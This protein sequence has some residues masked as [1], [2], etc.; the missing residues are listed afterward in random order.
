MN[1]APVLTQKGEW[2]VHIKKVKRSS[3]MTV[4]EGFALQGMPLVDMVSPDAQ[5]G[6]AV[7]IGPQQMTSLPGRAFCVPCAAVAVLSGAMH[8]Q[9]V[10]RPPQ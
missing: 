7:A 8:T 3:I 1:I 5:H 4:K 2:W 6:I 9:S 10:A